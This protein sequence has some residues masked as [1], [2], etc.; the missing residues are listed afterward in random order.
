VPRNGCTL[1]ASVHLWP[2]PHPARPAPGSQLPTV[3]LTE[4]PTLVHA[5]EVRAPG[6]YVQ[7]RYDSREQKSLRELSPPRFAGSMSTQ[8]SDVLCQGLLHAGMP[9][10]HWRCECALSRVTDITSAGQ[11]DP[12]LFCRPAYAGRCR[13]Q[14]DFEA[15]QRTHNAWYGLGKRNQCRRES[16]AYYSLLS[17]QAHLPSLMWQPLPQQ[18]TPKRSPIAKSS[19][20]KPWK[21]WS[22]SCVSLGKCVW[23]PQLFSSPAVGFREV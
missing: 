2:L 1:V 23:C 21:W 8:T 10:V 16:H 11:T 3:V 13:A 5:W 22:S 19:A 12:S 15:H 9:L 6:T 20:L 14:G 4:I 7:P 18:P 17:G